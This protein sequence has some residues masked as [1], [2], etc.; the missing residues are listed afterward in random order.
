LWR[1]VERDSRKTATALESETPRLKLI[2][3]ANRRPLGLPQ[4]RVT[5]PLHPSLTDGCSWVRHALYRFTAVRSHACHSGQPAP[6][7]GSHGFDVCACV[8]GGFTHC[9]DPAVGSDL[10]AG[11]WGLATDAC[12]DSFTVSCASCFSCS[13]SHRPACELAGLAS[14]PCL[15]S[16]SLWRSL[17]LCHPLRCMRPLHAVAR[18]CARTKTRACVTASLSRRATTAARRATSSRTAVA[19]AHRPGRALLLKTAVSLGCSGT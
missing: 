16:C 3:C 12:A 7:N 15:C 17:P 1:G 6:C 19:P 9:S 2:D 10:G 8:A 5:S 4:P 14:R 18:P 11:G 13:S